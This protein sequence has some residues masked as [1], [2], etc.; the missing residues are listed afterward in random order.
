M[1]VGFG[2]KMKP[3]RILDDFIS[4][5]IPP[6]ELNVLASN[7]GN[8]GEGLCGI[9]SFKEAPTVRTPIACP[10]TDRDTVCT[11]H[12]RLVDMCAFPNSFQSG[13]RNITVGRIFFI[14]VDV[15]AVVAVNM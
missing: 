8:M 7:L 15:V 14:V 1:I 13:E 5:N 3:T 9:V 10:A 6:T 11:R 2:D 4:G 12:Y